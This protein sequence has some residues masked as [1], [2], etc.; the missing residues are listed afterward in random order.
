MSEG[1]TISIVLTASN[2]GIMLAWNPRLA[3]Y[4]F[5]PME[6]WPVICSNIGVYYKLPNNCR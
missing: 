3:V 1:G 6:P 2:G 4:G 5:Q